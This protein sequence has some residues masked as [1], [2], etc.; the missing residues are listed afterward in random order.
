M[1][2]LVIK[3]ISEEQWSVEQIVGEFFFGKK[4]FHFRGMLYICTLNFLSSNFIF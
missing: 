2:D 1:K 4:F 3:Y